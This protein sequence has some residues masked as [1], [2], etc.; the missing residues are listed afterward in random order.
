MNSAN[1]TAGAKLTPGSPR[2]AS[3]SNGVAIV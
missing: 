1:L 3:M 2:D